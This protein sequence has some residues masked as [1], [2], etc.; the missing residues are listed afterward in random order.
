ME[1]ALFVPYAY[2]LHEQGKLTSTSSVRG[3]APLYF[4]SPRHVERDEARRYDRLREL[5]NVDFTIKSLNKGRWSPPPFRDH[6]AGIEIPLDT[7]KPVVVINNK[8]CVEWDRGSVHYIPPDVLHELV[9]VLASKFT[10]VYIRPGRDEQ[11]G[12]NEDGNTILQTREDY[13]TVRRHG[14][15]V[16]FQDVLDA[17]ALDFNTLQFAICS[18]ARHF[19]AVQGGNAVTACMFGGTCVIYAKTGVEVSTGAYETWFPNLSG[20]EVEVV[21]DPRELVTA[22]ARF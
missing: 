5:D 12:Y 10:V 1:L 13:D 15:V 9:E 22:A 19:I 6:F 21:N 16:V 7:K 3:T 20:T 14:R 11:R 4:F 17:C 18:R 8:Y 2:W